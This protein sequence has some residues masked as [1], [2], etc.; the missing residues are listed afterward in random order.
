MTAPAGPDRAQ[1]AGSPT[2]PA[3]RSGTGPGATGPDSPGPAVPTPRRGRLALAICVPLGVVLLLFVVLLATRDPATDRQVESA[4]LGRAAPRITGTTIEGRPF[5]SSTYDGRWLVVNF[6]A[7]WCAPCI[8][9]HPELMAFQ[10]AQAAAGQAN[11]ISV[12]FSDDEPSVRR[13]FQ[14][15]G[16]DWPV[17]LATGTAIPDWGVTGVPE[18][19][20]VDPAGVVRAKLVGGVTAAGL[21]RFLDRAQGGPVDPEAPR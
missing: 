14:R 5:D 13:F 19:F 16:G 4:L 21:Q 3:R 17:V 9:E 10:R 15:E 20:I 8:Q 6:F 2:R 18:S 1:G 11:V 7:T 12:V